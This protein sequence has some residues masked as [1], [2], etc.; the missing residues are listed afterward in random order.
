[1]EVLLVASGD[2]AVSLPFAEANILDLAFWFS[3]ESV[4]TGHMVAVS[5][6]AQANEVFNCPSWFYGEME[7]S[8]PVTRFFLFEL[9]PS[10]FSY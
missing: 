3:R 9:T 2:V 1:M 7:T 10:W 8:P 6:W 5:R 4:T